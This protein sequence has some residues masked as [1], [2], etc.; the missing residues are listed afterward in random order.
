[1][2]YTSFKTNKD[3]KRNMYKFVLKVKIELNVPYGAGKAERGK[4]RAKV[5]SLKNKML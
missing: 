4:E 1:M 5:E 3:R 2:Y